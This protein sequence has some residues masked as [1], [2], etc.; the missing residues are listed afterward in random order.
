MIK[1]IKRFVLVAFLLFTFSFSLH[2]KEKDKDIKSKSTEV[3]KEQFKKNDADVKEDTAKKTQANSEEP[4]PQSTAS[5]TGSIDKLLQEHE[6]VII[7]DSIQLNWYVFPGG[8]SMGSG[9]DLQLAA[10]SGQNFVG[11]YTS[12]IYNLDLGFFQ[13]FVPASCCVGY[14]GNV[15]EDGVDDGTPFSLTIADLVRLAAFMLAGDPPPPCIAEADIDGSD[16]IDISDVV[17]LVDFMF[18]NGPLPAMCP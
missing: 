8:I 2:A 4:K 9:G 16:Q 17:Q 5:V 12:P 10:I 18:R 15:T 1:T 7:V 11:S 14:R 6:D 3:K 13:N